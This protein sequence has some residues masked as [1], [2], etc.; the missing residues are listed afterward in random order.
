M[1]A[2]SSW[3]SALALDVEVGGGDDEVDG[4]AEALSMPLPRAGADAQHGFA[5]DLELM[6]GEGAAGEGEVESAEEGIG[7]EGVGGGGGVLIDDSGVDDHAEFG[8]GLKADI[9]GG[10]AVAKAVEAAI[11]GVPEVVGAG[12]G[13]AGVDDLEFG[14]DKVLL[15]DGAGGAVVGEEEVENAGRVHGILKVIGGELIKRIV[16]GGGAR[17]EGAGEV[18]HAEKR[19]A[20]FAPG[21][22]RHFGG[23]TGFGI[24][25]DGFDDGFHVATDAAAVVGE[26]GGDAVDIGGAGVGGDEALD[27]LFADEG[28]HVG[29]I[30]EVV[31]GGVDVG[32]SCGAGVAGTGGAG[33]EGMGAEEEFGVAVVFG[34]PHFHGHGEDIR[35]GVEDVAVAEGESGEDAGEFGDVAVVISGDGLAFGVEL[36]GAVGVELPEADGEKLHDFPGEV[37]VGIDAVDGVGLAVAEVAEEDAHG[38]VGGDV[39]EEVAVVAKGMFDHEIVVVGHALMLN[40]EAFGSVGDHKDLAEGEGDALAQGIG[41]LGSEGDGRNGVA[42]HGAVPPGELFV[43]AVE[44]GAVGGVAGHGPVDVGLQVADG[45]VELM[46]D[47]SGEA[48]GDDVL[49]VGRNGVGSNRGGVG[50]K[51]GLKE[52]TGGRLGG[53]LSGSVVEVEG[54]AGGRTQGVAGAGLEG[55]GDGF[56]GFGIGVGNGNELDPDF[57]GVEWDGDLIGGE[58]GVVGAAGS[59][60][61]DG[62]KNGE[63]LDATAAADGDEAVVGP[64]FAHGLVKHADSDSAGGVP[65]GVD[66]LEIG[67]VESVGAGTE[68]VKAEGQFFPVG[69]AIGVGVEVADAEAVE[70]SGIG[71]VEG[72]FGFLASAGDGEE[73]LP[74]VGEEGFAGVDAVAFAGEG[75]PEGVNRGAVGFDF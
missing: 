22:I 73:G 24:E 74:G 40:D 27:E 11:D 41:V 46:G 34:V 10:G 72:E 64:V 50:S 62:E 33:G 12:D 65:V 70:M 49:D 69:E 2:V 19:F 68:G 14:S 37:F 60:A 56:S 23:I 58:G 42:A 38:R 35:V 1:S 67:G 21:G 26:G 30:E 29:M 48:A 6:G 9:V 54:G 45:A 53:G 7:I 43:V 5:D 52:K 51:G 47:P 31:D 63:G 20:Q 36:A 39:V 66:L 18:D 15:G 75:G 25:K 3:R 8:V 13:G 59:A 44:A 71:E 16:A 17:V 4:E 57:A 28:P 32:E 61:V 55:E